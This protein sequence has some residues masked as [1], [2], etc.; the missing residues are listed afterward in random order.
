MNAYDD[1]LTEIKEALDRMSLRK[2]KI[3]LAFIRTFEPS[4]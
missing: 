4:H 3:V 2:L 1:M